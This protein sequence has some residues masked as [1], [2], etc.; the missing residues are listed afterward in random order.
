[1]HLDLPLA[2]SQGDDHVGLLQFQTSCRAVAKAE[3]YNRA[4]AAFG[5]DRRISKG[6][7]LVLQPVR[8][9]ADMLADPIYPEAM[10]ILQRLILAHT[11]DVAYG[12]DFIARSAGGRSSSSH[13]PG[14]QNSALQFFFDVQVS[15]A[16]PHE[17]LVGGAGQKVDAHRA[18][19]NGN[20]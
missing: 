7:K 18:H 13:Q 15:E 8:Q 16:A 4:L 19:I 3:R 11:A 9:R 2:G 10:N 5:G 12:A 17:P 1:P 14:F 6:G 20:S